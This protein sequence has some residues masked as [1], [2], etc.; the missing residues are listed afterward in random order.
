MFIGVPPR[1][2]FQDNNYDCHSTQAIIP[3]N[4]FF[5][6]PFKIQQLKQKPPPPA[7]TLKHLHTTANE[8]AMTSVENDIP[9]E[10]REEILETTIEWPVLLYAPSSKRQNTEYNL[11]ALE[12]SLTA[13]DNLKVV[14]SDD[15][16]SSAT[17]LPPYPPHPLVNATG[18]W[19]RP[20]IESTLDQLLAQFTRDLDG[21]SAY[22][23]IAVDGMNGVGKTTLCNAM[24]RTYIK[25][26]CIARDVS[27]G[28]DYNH[29]PTKALRYL[30]TH[31]NYKRP[32]PN[33]S[34]V[35]DRCIFSNL[36]FY[37]VHYL[38]ERARPLNG[39][40][41]L[42][43]M[44]L[45]ELALQCNL[46]EIIRTVRATAK[47]T[48]CP[49]IFIV[50]SDI[51]LVC[52]NLLHRN[53]LNDIFNYNQKDYQWAQYHAYRYFAKILGFPL[54][55]IAKFMYAKSDNISAY[56]L[57]DIQKFLR[58][59]I[60]CPRK[61]IQTMDKSN[62][63]KYDEILHTTNEEEA[64]A[65]YM[66]NCENAI[67]HDYSDDD[68]ET[69]N[70][71]IETTA[72]IYSDDENDGNPE[73]NTHQ[74][75]VATPDGASDRMAS[76]NFNTVGKSELNSKADEQVKFVA[77]QCQAIDHNNNN[78]GDGNGNNDDN[79][80]KIETN[81]HPNTI[82]QQCSTVDKNFTS[83]AAKSTVTA[84]TSTD[85]N[86]TGHGQNGIKVN[87]NNS[88]CTTTTNTTTTNSTILPSAANVTTNVNK[89]TVMSKATF[90]MPSSS[91]SSSP[92]STSI[93]PEFYRGIIDKE[94]YEASKKLMSLLYMLEGDN[95]L[96]M[97]FSHK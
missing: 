7:F 28:S 6:Y 38:M 3:N 66:K 49:T 79:S 77:Q 97:N 36:I 41:A 93:K 87:C 84:T 74:E 68:N 59:C 72:P 43:D 42:M 62:L 90:L 85:V 67:K 16:S 92:S 95:S 18:T 17:Q 83:R 24:N 20:N 30:W 13:F 51:E 21:W 80:S 75:S 53:S 12:E 25:V 81:S 89:A 45:N 31:V 39:D 19:T 63:A 14:K 57:S 11:N 2:I 82:S 27:A 47:D 4:E 26:N 15:S 5:Y 34:Y 88:G 65:N 54:V 37:F 32:N 91:W 48:I 73:H 55:D 70:D 40:C 33:E 44:Y 61:T 64:L 23:M 35:W 69:T 56:N 96:F 10:C 86:V 76:V 46:M 78:S 22:P 8:A 52:N 58:L 29:D 9:H 50:S 1:H 71:N 94:G 60:D